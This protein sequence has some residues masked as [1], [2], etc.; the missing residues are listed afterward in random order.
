MVVGFWLYVEN[1]NILFIFKLYEF[2]IHNQKN[3]GV[4]RSENEQCHLIFYVKLT[5]FATGSFNSILWINTLII[6]KFHLKIFIKISHYDKI[7]LLVYKKL[8]L[9]YLVLQPIHDPYL[10]S[11]SNHSSVG[12]IL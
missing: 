9:A 7:L 4:L 1:C 3:P 10:F 8:L 6:Y 2:L 11:L 5:K 12:Y